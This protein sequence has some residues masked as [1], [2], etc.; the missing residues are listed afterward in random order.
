[1][2]NNNVTIEGLVEMSQARNQ[3]EMEKQ[4]IIR[5]S[6]PLVDPTPVVI[7][8]EHKYVCTYTDTHNIYNT[9]PI[10]YITGPLS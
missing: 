10:Q 6:N 9:S 4:T 5:E 2:Y 8:I 1:M 3:E 7:I